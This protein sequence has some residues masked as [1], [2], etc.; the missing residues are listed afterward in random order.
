MKNIT[1]PQNLKPSDP[2][3]GAGPSLVPVE[4]IESLLAT[5]PHLLGTSHRKKPVKNLCKGIQDGLRQYFSLPD[6][7]SVVLG[8]GGATL[9]FDMIGLGMVKKR[10]FTIL[11]VS[12]VKS[13]LSL[14]IKFHGLRQKINLLILVR[15]CKLKMTQQQI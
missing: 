10:V 2:R 8:N 12:L 14:I 5:C 9:L 3:F 11:V 15:D 6:N 4:F 13:G 7:Y 1:I